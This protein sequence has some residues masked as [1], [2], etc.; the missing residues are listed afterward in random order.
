MTDEM[1]RR[2]EAR[3]R[4]EAALLDDFWDLADSLV[5]AAVNE[6]RRTGHTFDA[7]RFRAEIERISNPTAMVK[8]L[9]RGAF[10]DG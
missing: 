6:A 2:E 7:E 3:A 4:L 10:L 1:L 5:E 9:V 8:R